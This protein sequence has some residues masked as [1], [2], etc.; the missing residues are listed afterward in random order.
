MKAKY[1]TLGAVFGV[2]I[3]LFTFAATS[4]YSQPAITFIKSYVPIGSSGTDEHSWAWFIDVDTD[5]VI[6]CR[7]GLPLNSAP[8]CAKSTGIP[9]N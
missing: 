9:R 8:Q 1:L 5:R 7:A 3:S 2:M 6:V 4:A